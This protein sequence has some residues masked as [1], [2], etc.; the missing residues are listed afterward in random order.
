MLL[1]QN[2]FG[3]LDLIIL[4]IG[5]LV[6][7]LIAEWMNMT[8]QISA[9]NKKISNHEHDITHAYKLIN[10]ISINICDHMNND[11]SEIR[12]K[13]AILNENINQSNIVPILTVQQ[14]DTVKLDNV[15]VL[16]DQVSTNTTEPAPTDASL[17]ISTLAEPKKPAKTRKPRK[18]AETLTTPT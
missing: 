12:S 10:Q 6:A 2:Y 11:I 1:F 18:K 5:A 13:L 3:G 15:D 4:G 9:L 7:Y 14:D 17:I 16:P 8:D